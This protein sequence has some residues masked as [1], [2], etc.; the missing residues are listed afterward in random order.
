MLCR[1]QS[2]LGVDG[3]VTYA[4][5]MVDAMGKMS[6]KVQVDR[7]RAQGEKEKRRALGRARTTIRGTEQS[8]WTTVPAARG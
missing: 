2:L 4:V 1:N 8:R 3:L 5:V 6:T 7:D